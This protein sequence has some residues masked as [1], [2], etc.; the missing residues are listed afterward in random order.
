MDSETE[1]EKRDA[2]DDAA[3]GDENGGDGDSAE[4]R[5]S[6]AIERRGSDAELVAERARD[7]VKKPSFW[8]RV[9]APT[10]T[11]RHR[12]A[13]VVGIDYVGVAGLTL[14]GC[15]NDAVLMRDF[16]ASKYPTVRMCV[17]RDV[18]PTADGGQPTRASIF[19]GLAWL[20]DG[21]HAGDRLFWHYSGHGSHV[22]D[23]NGDEPDGRD[24]CLVPLDV[25]RSGYIVDD[26]LNSLVVRR[27]RPGVALHVLFDCC[28]SG[29]ALDLPYV[30]RVGVD[31]ETGVR[32]KTTTK[33]PRAGLAAPSPGRVVLFA[34]CADD[35]YAQET[36]VGGRPHG[37]MTRAF[38]D[39]FRPGRPAPTYGA[40]LRT[41]RDRVRRYGQSVQISSNLP[42]DA[43]AKIS[44]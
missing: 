24:E 22:P 1:P 5:R 28:H 21:A 37:A 34:A 4:R 12:R 38:V 8:Q 25:R 15:V 7:V 16:L 26:A 31:R 3:G 17:D 2:A 27:M 35:Q 39:A 29:T 40:V 41:L 36:V 42:I 23:A 10:G 20:L 43:H 33:P 18:L 11:C 32:T 13:F 14:G 9:R 44:W 30:L 19:A 6:T